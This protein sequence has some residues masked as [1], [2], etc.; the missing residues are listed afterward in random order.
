MKL[1]GL[2]KY[3]KLNDEFGKSQPTLGPW[4]HGVFST[5]DNAK[6]ALDGYR[7]ENSKWRRGGH[8]CIFVDGTEWTESS[9]E[10]WY[11]HEIELDKPL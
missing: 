7:E 10:L 11:W 5:V 9:R 1:I 8:Y 4:L 2:F 3:L 6:S